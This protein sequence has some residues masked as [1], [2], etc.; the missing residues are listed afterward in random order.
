M[1]VLS[2]PERTPIHTFFC[3]YDLS[4]MPAGTKVGLKLM[5]TKRSSLICSLL[6][7]QQ[8]Y[9]LIQFFSSEKDYFCFFLFSPH[10]FLGISCWLVICLLILATRAT[11]FSLL[12][13][14]LINVKT[15][16]KNDVRSF[17]LDQQLLDI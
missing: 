9:L 12:F 5:K 14:V 13:A 7:L 11:L 8:Q 1:Q 10:I 16:I 17:S 2:N 6:P 15:Y 3:N 4:D